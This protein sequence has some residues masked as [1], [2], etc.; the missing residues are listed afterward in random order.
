MLSGYSFHRQNLCRV[1]YFL[2]VN[3][4]FLSLSQA[5]EFGFSAQLSSKLDQFRSYR[6]TNKG[7][8]LSLAKKCLIAARE[9]TR[10]ALIQPPRGT[11]YIKEQPSKEDVIL[12]NLAKHHG[13]EIELSVVEVLGIN[14]EVLFRARVKSLEVRK[15]K[16]ESVDQLFDDANGAALSYIKNNP[17]AVKR[18]RFSHTHPFLGTAFAVGN[19]L[20]NPVL[21][22]GPFSP[23][24]TF[25]TYHRSRKVAKKL[26]AIGLPNVLLEYVV[27]EKDIWG[28]RLN[29][30]VRVVPSLSIHPVIDNDALARVLGQ[31]SILPLVLT[32]PIF[33]IP[34]LLLLPL[35]STLL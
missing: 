22:P 7:W 35:L 19:L 32:S 9:C 30:H 8:P 33:V 3:F 15:V 13:K 31:L 12:W 27:L 24:D 10:Y 16:S 11:R 29:K 21:L 6:Q 25:N 28:N 14:R 2:L 26:N 34:L 20:S 5:R 23:P 17:D 18:I 4:M 1:V